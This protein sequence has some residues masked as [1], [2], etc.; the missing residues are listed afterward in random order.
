MWAP[1]HPLTHAAESMGLRF[2]SHG[3]ALRELTVTDQA[4]SLQLQ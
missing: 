3:W 2:K 1:L 4:L